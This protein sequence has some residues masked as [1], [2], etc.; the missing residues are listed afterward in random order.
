MNGLNYI[1]VYVDDNLLEKNINIIKNNV[2]EN[3]DNHPL[4]VFM[5]LSIYF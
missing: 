5:G 2:N 1:H 4:F 3:N